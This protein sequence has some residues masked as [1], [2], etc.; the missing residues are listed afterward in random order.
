M[1]GH[2]IFLSLACMMPVQAIVQRKPPLRIRGVILA[3]IKLVGLCFSDNFSWLT[4]RSA[5]AV[6]RVKE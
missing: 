5:N 4:V 2:R 6:N 3:V 1:V